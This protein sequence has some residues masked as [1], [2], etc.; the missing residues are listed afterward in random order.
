MPASLSIATFNLE[1]LDDK[2][3]NKPTHDERMPGCVIGDSPFLAM[4]FKP[5]STLTF[6]RTVR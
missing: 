4:T 2:P 1:N 3:V 6:S 5:Y